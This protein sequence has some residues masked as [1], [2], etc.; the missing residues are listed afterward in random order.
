MWPACLSPWTKGWCRKGSLKQFRWFALKYFFGL[1]IKSLTNLSIFGS[2][3]GIG[4]NCPHRPPSG[5]APVTV[6]RN[7]PTSTLCSVSLESSS[8]NQVFHCCVSSQ[9]CSWQVKSTILCIDRLKWLT[10]RSFRAYVTI[11]TITNT[12]QDL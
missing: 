10:V 2:T 9:N 5:Y 12:A 11:F 7:F 3:F 8:G 4:G 1:H 6:W